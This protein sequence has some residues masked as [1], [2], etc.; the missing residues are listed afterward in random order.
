MLTIRLNI[1]QIVEAIDGTRNQTE[2]REHYERGPKVVELQQ[3]V[4]EEDRRKD[5]HVFEPLQRAKQL[6]VVKHVAKIR[7]SE[8]KTKFPKKNFELFA[9]PLIFK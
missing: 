1:P 8:Q 5:E 3:I 7:L 9:N 6:D 4:A 2:R